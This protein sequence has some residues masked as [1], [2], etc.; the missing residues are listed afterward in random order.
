MVVALIKENAPKNGR[1]AGDRELM[2]RGRL[3]LEGNKVD[4]GCVVQSFAP[5]IV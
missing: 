2:G 1:D 5:D 3:E 4:V